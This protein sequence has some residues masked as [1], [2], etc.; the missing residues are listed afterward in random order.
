MLQLPAFH[1]NVINERAVQTL[2]IGYD[3][4]LVF[5]FNLGMTA[6]NRSVGNT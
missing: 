3:E 2:E 5:L 1:R 4:L 6:G